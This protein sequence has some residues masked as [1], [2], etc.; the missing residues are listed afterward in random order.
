[1][2]AK[3]GIRFGA[4]S[5]QIFEKEFEAGGFWLIAEN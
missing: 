3:Y 1:M 2:G 5:A 4:A